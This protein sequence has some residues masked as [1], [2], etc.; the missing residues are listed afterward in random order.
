V[1]PNAILRIP[2]WMFPRKLKERLLAAEALDNKQVLC[3]MLQALTDDAKNKLLLME[4]AKALAEA[5]VQ[6]KREKSAL[7]GCCVDI[8]L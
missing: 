7:I 1:N 2:D 4:A 8:E 5:V 3:V 6:E